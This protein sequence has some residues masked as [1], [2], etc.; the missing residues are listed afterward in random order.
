M[1]RDL[2]KYQDG[3]RSWCIIRLLA[4][5]MK[6]YC[7]VR[8]RLQQI[9]YCVYRVTFL[10]DQLYG[11]Q[12]SNDNNNNIKRFSVVTNRRVIQTGI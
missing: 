4:Y 1:T 6:H 9:M 8:V 3:N 2:R 12:Q 7:K 11:D 10:L 5:Q